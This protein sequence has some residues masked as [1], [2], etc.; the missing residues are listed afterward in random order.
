MAHKEEKVDEKDIFPSKGW[1]TAIRF[2]ECS[3]K[4]CHFQLKL[5]ANKMAAQVFR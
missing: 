5:M 4:R 2:F 1:F 3:D